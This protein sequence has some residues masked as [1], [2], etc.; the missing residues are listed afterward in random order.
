MAFPPQLGL[1]CVEQL[2]TSIVNSSSYLNGGSD[3]VYSARCGSDCAGLTIINSVQVFHLLS[4]RKNCT[5][6]A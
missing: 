4:M 6:I 3:A 5:C 2:Y 1:T